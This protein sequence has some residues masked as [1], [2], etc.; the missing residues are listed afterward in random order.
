MISSRSPRCSAPR[1]G[2]DDLP[3]MSG[4]L[5]RGDF[6]QHVMAD[7]EASVFRALADP[8][9]RQILQDLRDGEMAAGDIASRF[10]IK[11]PSVSRHAAAAASMVG[12]CG[13]PGNRARSLALVGAQSAQATF[14]TAWRCSAWTACSA[15]RSAGTRPARSVTASP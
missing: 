12:D 3:D 1:T 15:R 13:H 2:G 7:G 8:T 10:P 6:K 4:C 11:G 14:S 5:A 9:R